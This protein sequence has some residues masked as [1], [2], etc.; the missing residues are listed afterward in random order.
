MSGGTATLTSNTFQ[1]NTATAT[2]YGG[3]ASVSSGTGTTLTSNTF[4]SNTSSYGG[5][6]SAYVSGDTGTIILSDN[7][8]QSNTA[9]GYG[10]GVYVT[11]GTGTTLTSNTFENN[12][13]HNDGGGM[14]LMSTRLASL[15][16]N[17]IISNTA[18]NSGGGIAISGGTV[19]ATND[20]IANNTSLWEG[21][22]VY[23]GGS[24]TARH[25]TLVSNG[26]Y[27][28][29]TNGGSAVLTNTIVALHGLG[30][31]AGSNISADHT[32]FFNSSTPCS[33]GASCTN[34]LSGD[35]E[36]LNPAAEDYHIGS[37][38][39]AIDVGVDASVTTDIDGD[40]RP[41][42]AGYDV[43]ADEYPASTPC[44]L[45]GDLDGDGDV[46]VDDIMQV[47]GRWRT[48]CDNPD[49]DNNPDTPN[50]E[51]RYDLDDDCDID[52]VDI[53]LVVAHWGE[54]C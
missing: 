18:N 13:A 6:A 43:G 24:L 34:N 47:A 15:N 49:P 9:T 45:F 23:N 37:G 21:V 12:L 42:G 22:Y 46:D 29:T 35:P 30:G 25:W 32:L 33:S 14:H 51:A 41:Q 40:P 7:T 17:T 27:A 4:I 44:I 10:G 3:G 28:L 54:H 16:G 19:N 26:S 48:S 1:S 53:M 5:G 38:S 31:F 52:I 8:F 39:A 2:G 20:I 36:F 11:S 50:Y